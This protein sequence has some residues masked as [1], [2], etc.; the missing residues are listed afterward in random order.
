MMIN[1]KVDHCETLEEFYEEIRR[2]QEEA[3]GDKYCEQH[4]II[5][6]LLWDECETYKE[7]GTHQGGTAACALM[8]K[9]KKVDLVDISMEKYNKSK[10]L[11]EA[12][13]EKH[14]IEFVVREMDSTSPRSV[15]RTDLLVIDSLHHPNHLIKELNL[16]TQYVAKYIVCH[17]TARLHGKANDALYQVLK[18][19]VAQL[20][21]WEIVDHRTDNVGVTVLKRTV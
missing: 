12:Y 4:D 2:Q 15:S 10:H 1:S 8:Q 5:K 9:P 11:F 7:L 16:H 14:D 17:D 19:F 21:P 3:H 18:Q 20:N 6:Q 13:C